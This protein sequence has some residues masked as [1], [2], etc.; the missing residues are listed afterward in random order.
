MNLGNLELTP[1]CHNK[2]EQ[3]EMEKEMF[4]KKLKP[5]GS[6]LI[7][8]LVS[9]AS[10]AHDPIFGQGPHVLFKDG[11]EVATELHT[12]KRGD[13][14]EN[15]YDLEVKYGITGD[16]AMGIDIPYEIKAGNGQTAMG[17]GDSSI[18]TKYRFWR[19]DSK[20]LQESTAISLKVISNS[21]NENASPA[22]GSGTTDN[23]VGLSYGYEGRTWYR[24]ASIRHRQNGTTTA[25]LKRGNKTLVDF[26]VGIRPILT[27]YTEPDMVY[28]LELNGELGDSAKKNGNTLANT[29]GDEW[30]ISPGFMWT[31]KNFAV[32]GGVQLPVSSNLNG[33]QDKSDYRMKLSFEWHL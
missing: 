12:A 25:G 26:V 7:L 19:K 10:Y 21:G 27:K 16:W 5:I 32:R 22:L 4:L 15:A 14:L 31:V 33:T 8:G 6:V 20:G 24:W 29:G 23:V 18:F 3:I 28:L 13:E 1:C 2:Y 11:F 30:F 17:L 9:S